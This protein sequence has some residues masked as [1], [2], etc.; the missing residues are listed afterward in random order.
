M[1]SEPSCQECPSPPMTDDQSTKSLAFT[2]DSYHISFLWAQEGWLWNGI[3]FFSCH[4]IYWFLSLTWSCLDLALCV[5]VCVCVHSLF[6]AVS[7]SACIISFRSGE[8]CRAA[9]SSGKAV[10]LPLPHHWAT[11]WIAWL[12]LQVVRSPS[13]AKTTVK[14]KNQVHAWESQVPCGFS[15]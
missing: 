3:V 7:T 5:C 6:C 12:A 8:F 9:F 2:L 11:S 13:A 10:Y 15:I 1:F 14:V 4:I